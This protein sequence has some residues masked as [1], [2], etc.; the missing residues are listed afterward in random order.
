VGVVV[1]GWVGSGFPGIS[2]GGVNRLA[3]V[4]IA[5]AMFALGV[6]VGKSGIGVTVEIGVLV[7]TRV[8]V[9]KDNPVEGIGPGPQRPQPVNRIRNSKPNNDFPLKMNILFRINV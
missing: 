5:A 1:A 8:I 3:W 2:S 4:E 7:G 6:L 9:G